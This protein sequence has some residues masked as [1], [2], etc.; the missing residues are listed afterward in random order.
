MPQRLRQTVTRIGYSPLF[1][2]LLVCSS[3]HAGDILVNID[4]DQAS[5]TVYVALMQGDSQDWPTTPLRQATLTDGVARL[6]DVAPGG[7]AI[8][9][10]QDRNGNGRLDLS[11]R[12][13]PQEPVGFSGNPVLARGKP[14]P[15]SCR[16]EHAK[17]DTLIHIKLQSNRKP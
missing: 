15:A 14:T 1:M 4:A 8:Q 2:L 11:R 17:N 13:I 3:T 10:Y 12:G 9:V 6:S 16:F 7:Y 5:G